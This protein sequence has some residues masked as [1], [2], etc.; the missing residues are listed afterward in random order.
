MD[1][2]ASVISSAKKGAAPTVVR[3]LSAL[4]NSFYDLDDATNTISAIEKKVRA[5][6]EDVLKKIQRLDDTFMR[7]SMD[8]GKETASLAALGQ[9]ISS[10]AFSVTIFIGGVSFV[11]FFLFRYTFFRSL[12]V[13]LDDMKTILEIMAR[14]DLRNRLSVEGNDELTRVAQ[15]F[16]SF[17]DSITGLVGSKKK[18]SDAVDKEAKALDDLSKRMVEEAN[19]AVEDSRLARAEIGH[20]VEHV[21]H[22]GSMVENLAQA[23]NQI[24]SSTANTASLSEDLGSKIQGTRDII[25]KLSEHAKSIGEVIGLIGS[26][27]EQTNLLALNATIEAARAGEAGKGFA[28]VANEVKELAKQ[29]AEATEKIAPIISSIQNSIEESVNSINES[30]SAMEVLRDS[31]S[32]V[33]TAVEEQTATYSEINEQI[34]VINGSISSIRERVNLLADAARENLDESETLKNRASGLRSNSDELNLQISGL[35]V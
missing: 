19:A 3:A 23:T 28:V 12:I 17:L 33:A 14:G 32:T 11:V 6:R 8:A 5:K 18:V 16:N 4:E 2:V 22:T 15:S 30:V 7:L 20:I 25:Q 35:L 9:A 1:R 24:A 26:I 10:R 29:T 13:P 34:R 31:A 27:A 21:Q